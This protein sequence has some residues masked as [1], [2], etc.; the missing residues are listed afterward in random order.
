MSSEKVTHPLHSHTFQPPASYTWHLWCYK[1]CSKLSQKRQQIQL[2][3]QY[4][5]PLCTHSKSYV[6]ILSNTEKLK[7]VAWIFQVCIF[8]NKIV[9]ALLSF[10]NQV[11][12]TPGLGSNTLKVFK[13]KYK[14]S[15]NI[16]NTKYKYKYL[17]Q[18]VFQ[19]QIHLKVFS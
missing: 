9:T 17:H 11:T 3:A 19:I 15:E 2:T 8:W 4:N 13:Y 14:C 10:K 1:L 6:A 7:L 12:Y 18:D 16:W 5:D